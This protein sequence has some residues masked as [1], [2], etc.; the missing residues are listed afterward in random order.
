MGITRSAST[1]V[2]AMYLALAGCGGAEELPEPIVIAPEPSVAAHPRGQI[3][4]NPLEVKLSTDL[5]GDIFYTLD[6][7]DPRGPKG[8][9]YAGEIT[10]DSPAK[11]SFAALSHQGRWSDLEAEFYEHPEEAYRILPQARNL[12][13]SDDNIYFFAEREGQIMQR[14][15]TIRSVGLQHIYVEDIYAA[16]YAQ[17]GTPAGQVVFYVVEQP[18]ARFLAPGES[19][20]FTVRYYATKILRRGALVIKTDASNGQDGYYLVDLAGRIHLF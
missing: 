4:E 8:K 18:S 11:L 6:G 13:V 10:I 14:T 7:S 5:P 12:R 20:T 15:I 3:F 9:L 2:C 17:R 1:G 16:T 19:M